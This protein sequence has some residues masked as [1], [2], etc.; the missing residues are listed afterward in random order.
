MPTGVDW[1]SHLHL[2]DSVD[3][4][5]LGLVVVE[6]LVVV[7]E[8]G[9]LDLGVLEGVAGV[10]DVLLEGEGEVAAYGAGRSLAAV[11]GAGE[12]AH[13][14]NGVVAGVAAHDDGR[15]EHG[16]LDL[17]EE[18][19]VG[20]VRVVFVEELVGEL[21]HLHAAEVKAFLLEAAR[22]FAHE[23]AHQA[24]G[25]QDNECFLYHGRVILCS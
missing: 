5:N 25:L 1:N 23:P 7:E 22:D 13:D 3:V 8:T 15:L 18:W 12:G 9:Y 11:G 19:L 14:L 20:Q 2:L 16:N 6:K 4:V 17:R 10:D 21:H 24:V